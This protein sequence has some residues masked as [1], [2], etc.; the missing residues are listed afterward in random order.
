MSFMDLN[1]LCCAGYDSLPP[2]VID[3]CI[4][5][6]QLSRFQHEE[7]AF[8]FSHTLQQSTRMALMWNKEQPQIQS[9]G[10]KTWHTPFQWLSSIFNLDI[11]FF[12]ISLIMTRTSEWSLILLWENIHGSEDVF[13]LPAV[14][15]Y[16]IP[17]ASYTTYL[18]LQGERCTTQSNVIVN[19][20]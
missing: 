9:H 14:W 5:I 8:N 13:V 4:Q 12:H 6:C 10:T 19:Y 2:G 3:M 7:Q 1:V 18:R 15:A 16:W 17:A 11:S 20:S